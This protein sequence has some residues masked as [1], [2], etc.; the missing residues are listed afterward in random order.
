MAESGT[1]PKASPDVFTVTSSTPNTSI[2]SFI[3]KKSKSKPVASSTPDPK[4]PK[5]PM[6]KP[7]SPRKRNFP[8][9]ISPVPALT[10][11]GQDKSDSKDSPK[12]CVIF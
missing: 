4:E 6:A 10:T 5:S 3:F 7:P 8:C 11:S 1:P 12:E 2:K 9:N